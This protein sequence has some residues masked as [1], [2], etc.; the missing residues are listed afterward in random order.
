VLSADDTAAL[1]VRARQGDADAFTAL[2][3][4]FLR[5]AY[6]VA[7]AVVGRPQ[8]ADDVAQDAFVLAFERLDSC[9]EPARFRGWL[10]TIVRNQARNFLERRRLRDV[11]RDSRP[12]ELVAEGP[13]PDARRESEDLARA[14]DMLSPMRRE[15]VLLHDL[16][17][18]SHAEIAAALEIS[19]VS[20]RQYLFQA[21]REMRAA[22]SANGEPQ[23]G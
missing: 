4:A 14:L 10:L 12:P 8:D 13:A 1:V 7:L 3:R 15:V 11:P 16:D 5:S 9:R 23:N 21:R 6:A 17:G 22:L 20:S 19:E 18:W 2:S